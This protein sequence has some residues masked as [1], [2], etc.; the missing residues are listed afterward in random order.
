MTERQKEYLVYLESPHWKAL[1]GEALKRDGD[2]CTRCGSKRILQVHHMIYRTRFED[3]LLED[4]ITLCKECHQA[5]HGKKPKVKRIKRAKK[6][7][8]SKPFVV[9]TNWETLC[10]A[11]SNKQITRAEFLKQ[12]EVYRPGQRHHRAVF[13]ERRIE[14]KR[15]W[16]PGMYEGKQPGE[17]CL[18]VA[19]GSGVGFEP[20]F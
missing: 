20:N 2:K 3:S 12:K 11:R 16:W 5:E 13:R 6:V 15:R 9:I 14:G 8:K 1:R 19:T 17:A 7:R 18:A 10:R 4:L